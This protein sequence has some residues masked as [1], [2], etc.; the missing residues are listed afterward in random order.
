[1]KYRIIE[2]HV[3]SMLLDFLDD[4]QN[5]ALEENNLQLIGFLQDIIG[6][7]LDANQITDVPVHELDLT[8]INKDIKNNLKYLYKI[9]T[10]FD[11]ESK[12]T[13]K[14][15]KVEKKTP[16]ELFEEYYQKREKNK[17]HKEFKSLMKSLKN[18]GIYP[19]DDK[20]K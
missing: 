12:R 2:E 13:S 18:M 4:L 8:K 14:P 11:K 15:K 7:L 20:N 9:Y 16:E 10:E 19:S 3:V 1:M 5:E 6:E 17:A